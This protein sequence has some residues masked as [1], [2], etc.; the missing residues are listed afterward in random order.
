MGGRG[1]KG[2]T[3]KATEV[4][5]PDR[6]PPQPVDDQPRLPEPPPGEPARLVAD[7]V[8]PAPAVVSGALS[9]KPLAENGWGYN[10]DLPVSYHDDGPIGSAV[11]GMGAE[12]RM[13]VDGEPLANVL[14]VIATDVNAERRTAQQALDDF[15]ALRERLPAGRA[16]NQ[17]DFAIGDMDAPRAPAPQ[18]PTAAPAPLQRLAEKLND[19]PLVRRDP[20]REMDDLRRVA[21]EAAAGRL[22]GRRLI[23]EVRRLENRRHESLGECGKLEIDRAVRAAVDDLDRL[24]RQARGQM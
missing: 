21:A 6:K 23:E 11:K 12:A 13:D 9:D 16:R 17:L 19:V 2:R 18:L 20:S 8:P 14:G 1:S 7:D 3:Q 4:P 22:G 10:P 24:R 5:G 15:K